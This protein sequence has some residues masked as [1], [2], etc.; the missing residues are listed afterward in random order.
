KG[1]QSIADWKA[2]I[3]WRPSPA[4][5]ART[6]DRVNVRLGSIAALWRGPLNV[7]TAPDSAHCA[8][9]ARGQRRANSGHCLRMRI[10][11]PVG[12]VYAAADRVRASF[13]LRPRAAG[14]PGDD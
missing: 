7:R 9:M 6:S 2:T 10:V 11:K 14:K 13:Q 3:R 1:L 5:S 8:E 4:L 12:D